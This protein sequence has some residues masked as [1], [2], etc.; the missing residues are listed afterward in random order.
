MDSTLL[1]IVLVALMGAA[2]YA[3]ASSLGK[4]KYYVCYMYIALFV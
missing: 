3:S 4:D 2:A 1:S